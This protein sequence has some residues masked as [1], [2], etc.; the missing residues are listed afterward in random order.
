M[1]NPV[2][3]QAVHNMGGVTKVANSLL[4]S[5]SCVYK[6]TRLGRIPDIDHATKVAEASGYSVEQLRPRQEK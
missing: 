3:K 5:S 1:Q 2:I 6:W 4:V